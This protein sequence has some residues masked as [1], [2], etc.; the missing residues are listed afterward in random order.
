MGV[1]LVE[2][3]G[4]DG[5]ALSRRLWMESLQTTWGLPERRG[6]VK[7]K[8]CHHEECWSYRGLWASS[9]PWWTLVWTGAMDEAV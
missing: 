4:L 1:G 9:L 5:R 3:Q 8:R 6:D 2:Y 7:P